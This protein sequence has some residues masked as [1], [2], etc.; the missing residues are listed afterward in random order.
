MTNQEILEYNKRCAL[1]LGATFA[2]GW[3]EHSITPVYDF[4]R[5]LNEPT[6][7]WATTKY[8]V[9]T[10]KFHLDW[11]WIMEVVAKINSI[12]NLKKQENTTQSSMKYEIQYVLKRANKEKTIKVINKFLIWYNEQQ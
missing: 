12:S 5:K 2:E 11:N 8:Q 7:K 4:K 1:F 3:S 6:D 9:K 10:M